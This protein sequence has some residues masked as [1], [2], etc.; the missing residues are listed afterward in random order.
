[1]SAGVVTCCLSLFYQRGH[2]ED[3]LTPA[4]PHFDQDRVVDPHRQALILPS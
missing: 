2:V 4:A 3:R 1:M